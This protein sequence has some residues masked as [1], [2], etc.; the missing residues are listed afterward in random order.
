M[1]S[2]GEAS[3]MSK[4][5]SRI[6]IVAD[7]LRIVLDGARKTHIMYQCNLSYKLLTRYLRDVLEAELVCN[8]RDGNTYVI[9]K[10]GKLFLQKFESYLE[11]SE[12]V[13]QQVNDV[14][15]EKKLLESMVSGKNM[16]KKPGQI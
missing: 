7:I 8:E 15:R 13:D 1:N 2:S 10:K 5:R 14:N 12:R 9:T 4:Y 3:E 16:L 6:E 11:Q